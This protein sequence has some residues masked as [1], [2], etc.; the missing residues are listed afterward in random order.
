M[1]KY[2]KELPENIK[3]VL[4]LIDFK[5]DPNERYYPFY[6]ALYSE[7][8]MKGWDTAHRNLKR[9]LTR[10]LELVKQ[11][12]TI[13]HKDRENKIRILTLNIERLE[14]DLDFYSEEFLW[15]HKSKYL[16]TVRSLT[17]GV[18]PMSYGDFRYNEIRKLRQAGPRRK[19]GKKAT[20]PDE[21]TR[22]MYEP[23]LLDFE[24]KNF[25]PNLKE[26]IKLYRMVN[27]RNLKRFP[28][29]K[30]YQYFEGEVKLVFKNQHIRKNSLEKDYSYLKNLCRSKSRGLTTDRFTPYGYIAVPDFFVDADDEIRIFVGGQVAGLAGGGG[31]NYYDLIEGKYVFR[32]HANYWR[33]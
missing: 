17:R 18:R 30:V 25:N 10:V 8:N 14:L 7:V 6:F 13:N 19:V 21:E 32:G 33:S 31:A 29:S 15:A 3:K 22:Q 5:F 20:I 4:K 27:P 23:Y 11:D 24:K 16:N 2:P 9:N 12:E 28:I 1:S 26:Y